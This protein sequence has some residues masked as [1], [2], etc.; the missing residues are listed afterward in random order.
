VSGGGRERGG[1]GVSLSSHQRPVRGGTDVWLTPPEIIETVGPF[2]LDPCAA[3]DQPWPTAARHYTIN[4]DG[5]SLPW[6]GFAWVNPP[7]GP[8]AERWLRRLA[9]H[10]HGIGLVPARTETRW[11]VGTIWNVADAVLFLHGRPHFHHAD[12]TRAA[13]NSGAPICLIGYGQLAVKR[14]SGCGLSGSL[15][16]KWNSPIGPERTST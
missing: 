12:G 16:T 3:V 15:V 8:D 14:L 2:D 9:E 11:F 1:D 4:D 7:F 6:E 13:A 5:L 10:G